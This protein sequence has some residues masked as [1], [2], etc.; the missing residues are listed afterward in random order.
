MHTTPLSQ[1]FIIQFNDESHKNNGLVWII[2]L[3]I[4]D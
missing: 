4:A 3:W 2:S 1:S